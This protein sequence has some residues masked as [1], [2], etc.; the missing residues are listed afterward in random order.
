MSYAD[1]V[2]LGFGF[3]G[4]ATLAYRG[5]RNDLYFSS[6]QTAVL[7]ALA[8]IVGGL[9][10]PIFVAITALVLSSVDRSTETINVADVR[11]GVLGNC[12]R[13]SGQLAAINPADTVFIKYLRGNSI[14]YLTVKTSDITFEQKDMEGLIA[15][16]SVP[17]RKLPAWAPSYATQT[18]LRSEHRVTVTMSGPPETIK[19]LIEKL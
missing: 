11:S 14:H 6:A 18:S 16:V 5:V 12:N 19:S 8:G 13:K 15:E 1:I 17:K 10:L 7:T 4:S 2:W 9:L 3:I